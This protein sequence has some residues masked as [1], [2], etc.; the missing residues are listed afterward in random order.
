M[1]RK[2]LLA[3]FV[4][5]LTTNLIT[6]F[7]AEKTPAGGYWPQFRGPKRDDVST[8]TGLLK[9][10]PKDGPK[11]LWEAK[12]AGR[13]YSSVAVVAGKVYTMGDD[14]KDEYVICLDEATG[15][16]LWKAKLGPAW[17]TGMA[18][19]QSSRAPRQ[20]WTVTCCMS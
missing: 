8:D 5:V 7:A 11:L 16:E 4:L 2:M 17:T 3:S 6:V 1:F 12:G 10:W 15:K 14:E 18:N 9:E 20:P 19:W 13:G